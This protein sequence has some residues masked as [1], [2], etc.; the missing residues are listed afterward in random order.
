MGWKQK[1]T[2]H[3]GPPSTKE[4]AG[5][6]VKFSSNNEEIKSLMEIEGGRIKSSVGT[7][8]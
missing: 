8:G 3:K 5:N 7:R 4:R 2:R 1:D 6:M